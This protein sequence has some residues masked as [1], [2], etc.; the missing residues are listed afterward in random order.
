MEVYPGVKHSFAVND[1]PVFDRSTAE[2]HWQ[3]I[4]NLF[5]EKLSSLDDQTVTRV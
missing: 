5:A 4:L 1:I 2:R 3:Q